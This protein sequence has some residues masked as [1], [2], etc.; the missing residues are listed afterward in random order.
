MSEQFAERQWSISPGWRPKLGM[1]L[2][3]LALLS[4][5]LV[6]CSNRGASNVGESK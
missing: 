4:P 3:I 6:P 1:L 5:L 2:F